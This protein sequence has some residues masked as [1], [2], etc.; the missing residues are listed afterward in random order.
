MKDY[1]RRVS[2][3]FIS[4]LRRFHA[5][6]RWSKRIVWYLGA[7]LLCIFSSI[8]L[9]VLLVWAGMFGEMPSK[10]ELS[11][12]NHQV[13]TEIFSADSILLGRYY[14]QERSTVPGDQVGPALKHALVATE[15]VRFF[16]HGGV[17]TRS[18]FRVLIKS[19]LLQKES[20]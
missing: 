13:A 14:W 17:D 16:K 6:A 7:L 10:K 19:I 12:I 4:K 18:L 3:L 2:M 8:L 5:D 11:S 1:F 9:L 20:S 15:D